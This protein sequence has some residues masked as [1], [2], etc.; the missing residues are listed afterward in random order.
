MSNSYYIVPVYN[1]ERLILD[2]LNG[3]KT[4]HSSNNQT[5][6]CIIDG[7][8]DTSEEKVL[9]FKK[10]SGINTILLYENNVHEIRCLNTALQYIKDNCNP[11]PDDLIFTVQDDVILDEIN[12]DGI[13]RL[14]FTEHPLAA[15][16]SITVGV[17]VFGIDG[18]LTEANYVESEFGHWDQL[19]WSFHKRLNHYEYV[20]T[21]V[22]IRSP[23][24]T[25]WKRF[26]D[27]GFFDT[28]LE[29]CGFDC[30]EFSIRMNIAGYTNYVFALKFK[31]DVNWGTM[32]SETQSE[33]SNKIGA[34]YERNKKYIAEEHENYFERKYYE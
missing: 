8:T 10:S 26:A 20:E 14:F 34:I 12:I 6:I 25:L 24:C 3:I 33:Y 5:I 17:S 7:C 28:N 4:S 11:A 18:Y 30:H 2:V 23:T 9:Q 22:A 1:K 19:N 21:E 15:Y 13:F 29:P 31:S 16:V 27:H 32:R